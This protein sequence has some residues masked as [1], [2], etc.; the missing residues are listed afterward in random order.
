MRVTVP[1]SNF[2]LVKIIICTPKGEV[3]TTVDDSHYIVDVALPEGVCEDEVDVYSCFLGNN[4]LPPYGCGPSLLQAATRKAAQPVV[5]DLPDEPHIEEP[6]V[7]EL[8]VM[9]TTQVVEEPEIKE[10]MPFISAFSV[11]EQDNEEVPESDSE[12]K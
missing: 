8:P 5:E 3:S 10:Q 9:P 4:N 7:E 2:P 11:A 1:K 12:D 6:I